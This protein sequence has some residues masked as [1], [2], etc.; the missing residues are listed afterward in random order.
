MV[1]V[2]RTAEPAGALSSA[3]DDSA[4]GARATD[5]D[6]TVVARSPVAARAV[7]AAA[8][9][10]VPVPSSGL[11]AEELRVQIRIIVE[12]AIGPWQRALQNQQRTILELLQRLEDMERKIPSAARTPVGAGLPNLAPTS[13]P[14]FVSAAPMGLVVDPPT[15]AAFPV[16]AAPAPVALAP[17]VAP[18]DLS[19]VD[20]RV[21][22][23]LEG[24]SRQRHLIFTAVLVVV[25]LFGGLGIALALS[26]MPQSH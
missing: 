24:R 21:L 8:P 17:V 3:A 22:A 20:Q 19:T 9:G 13:M 23:A 1:P 14:P 2:D 26:Y 7:E 10:P 12:D 6:A 25:L 5:E 4:S 11:A 16:A 18:V 15:P